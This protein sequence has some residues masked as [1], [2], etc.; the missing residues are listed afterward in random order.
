[1][2]AAL[3]RMSF[4]DDQWIDRDLN[5][6]C[7]EVFLWEGD[8]WVNCSLWL[9]WPLTDVIPWRLIS[10]RHWHVHF[11]KLNIVCGKQ[12]KQTNNK[13]NKTKNLLWAKNPEGS[14]WWQRTMDLKLCSQGKLESTLIH[15]LKINE[16]KRARILYGCT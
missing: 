2:M 6:L 1:M 13:Q 16:G 8:C 4:C 15:F 5:W 9:I 10:E 11:K 12:N 7:D 14:L 3:L